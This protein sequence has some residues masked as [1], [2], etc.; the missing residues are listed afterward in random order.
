MDKYYFVEPVRQMGFWIVAENNRGHYRQ[1]GR[2]ST[3]NAAK[4]A[5]AT[6][7]AQTTPGASA[8]DLSRAM[9]I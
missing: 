2:Y 6:L 3:E 9:T 7:N 8:S 1:I 5:C 4:R